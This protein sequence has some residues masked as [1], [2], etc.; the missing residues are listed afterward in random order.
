MVEDL[1]TR[2]P[3]LDEDEEPM[4]IEHVP[5]RKSAPP[6]PMLPLEEAAFIPPLKQV[7]ALKN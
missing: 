1:P 3:R 4:L 7:P 5:E 2:L 6:P